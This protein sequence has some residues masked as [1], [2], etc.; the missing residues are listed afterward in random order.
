MLIVGSAGSG[1]TSTLSNLIFQMACYDRVYLFVKNPNEPLYEHLTDV[2][3]E[4]EE[5]HGVE[6]ITVSNDLNDMPD[7]DTDID[8]KKN[9]LIV[10]DDMINEKSKELDRVASFFTRGRHKNLTACFVSQSYFATPKKIRQNLTMVFFKQLS[11]RD[12][13]L[14]LTEFASDK[15]VKELQAMYKKCDTSKVENVFVLDQS[16]GQE[17]AFKYRCGFTPIEWEN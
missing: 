3:Q 9:T 13:R 7:L 15:T 14:V 5:K 6:L 8:P 11:Q 4:L 2:Y 10:W 12:L 17:E 16:P 1:K